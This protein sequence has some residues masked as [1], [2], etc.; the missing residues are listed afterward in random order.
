MEDP[1]LH[2]DDDLPGIGLV[3]APIEVLGH[4]TK[5]DDE[6]ARQVLRLNF[7][8]LLPPQPH[9]AA[10]SVPMMIRASEPPMKWRR[11]PELL[12]HT[13]FFIASSASKNDVC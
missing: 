5:L 12:F 6:I 11:S 1:L 13:W 2:I 9:Q 7:S 10:S 8:P 3:P 4:N